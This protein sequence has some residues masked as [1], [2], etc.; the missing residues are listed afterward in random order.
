M[1]LTGGKSLFRRALGGGAF[2]AGS[3]V[4]AQFARLLSNL[5]LTRLLYP[6]AFGVMALVMVVLVG[7][8]M[9]S[10]V[11]IGP[12]ISRSARGDDPD[13]LNTA[14]TLNVFR[15]AGLWVLTCLVAWPAAW[16]YGVPELALMVPV[17]GLTLLIG[18]FNP[19]RID[20]ANRHLL[21]VRVTLLDLAAQI[22]GI[23]VM[24]V[25]AWITGSIW[26]LVVGAVA[27]VLLKLCLSSAFLPGPANRFRWEPDAA[28]ELVHFGKWILASTAAG[29]LLTQGDKAVLG[30][31]LS[32]ADLGHYNIGFFLASFPVLLA[33]LVVTRIMI[34]IYRELG[35]HADP[36]GARKLRHLR[37][38]L[39]IPMLL[40][41]GAMA[42]GG[43]LIAG[44][45][46]DARYRDV[47]VII[48]A[49]AM[50]QMP[51]L[52]GLTYDQAALAAGDGRGFFFVQAIRAALQ[53]TALIV[54]AGWGGLGG[55]LLGQG[56]ALA[57]THPFLIR[58]ARRH[59][60]WDPRHDLAA[61]ALALVLIIALCWSGRDELLTL[62]G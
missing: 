44:V 50:A 59:K 18:G 13:F 21:L 62:F 8:Q 14:W 52:I 51:M 30:S 41:M 32:M 26:A 11:G 23:V 4:F 58:L 10:D 15:G 43:D 61:A 47:G 57:L 35:P 7:L 1:E 12:A 49:V 16:F 31:W 42:A 54:G 22:G 19:T 60:A 36:A 39:T 6:E 55:A 56:L 27:Q 29:F 40:V 33:G 34:P 5:V 17:A 24:V 38:G 37:F 2:V 20:T 48:A 3:Y 53:T 9:F 46:Y 45:L 28:R 25:F